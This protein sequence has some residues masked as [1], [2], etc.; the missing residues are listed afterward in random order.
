MIL[1]IDNIREDPFDRI[2]PLLSILE[3]DEIDDDEQRDEI[4]ILGFL[5]EKKHNY[6]R[7][8][9]SYFI[10]TGWSFKFFL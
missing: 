7:C 8:P 1:P 3:E 6:S 2:E 10:A 4:L 9:L 5:E